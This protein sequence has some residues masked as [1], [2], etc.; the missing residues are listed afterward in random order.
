[1]CLRTHDLTVSV[2]FGQRFI[3]RSASFR[4]AS[5][6]ADDLVHANCAQ[7]RV[8]SVAKSARRSFVVLA[9]GADA[10]VDP[11]AIGWR[12]WIRAMDVQVDASHE[13]LTVK[14]CSQM[15]YHL[16][17]RSHSTMLGLNGSG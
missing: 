2:S 11:N 4:T 1:M 8:H 13:T 7:H 16:M 12:C 14:R 6:V 15:S 17:T 10:L 9:D 3:E 5:A